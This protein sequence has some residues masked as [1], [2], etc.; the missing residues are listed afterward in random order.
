MDERDRASDSFPGFS[1]AIKALRGA[2][3]HPS[4]AVAD[5]VLG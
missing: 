4:R 1:E 5:A 3:L 2:G